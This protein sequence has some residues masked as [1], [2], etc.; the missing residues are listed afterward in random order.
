[1]RFRRLLDSGRLPCGRDFLSR[2][3]R[4]SFFRRSSLALPVADRWLVVDRLLGTLGDY[5][6]ES[7]RSASWD[8]ELARRLSEIEAGTAKYVTWEEVQQRLLKLT[9]GV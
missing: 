1:M 5:H 3:G 7:E 9:N 8:R 2:S 6:Y 4:E